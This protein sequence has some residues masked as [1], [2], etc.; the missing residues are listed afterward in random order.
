[1]A[2]EEQQPFAVLAAAS[3]EL[4]RLDLLL[5]DAAVEGAALRKELAVSVEAAVAAVSLEH[6]ASFTEPFRRAGP[7]LAGAAATRR[8]P[9]LFVEDEPEQLH[10]TGRLGDSWLRH[11]AG[12]EGTESE[13]ASVIKSLR[14]RLEQLEAG[15]YAKRD[16]LLPL[17][18][19]LLP[20]PE[21]WR[22]CV[23][24]R[25]S[26]PGVLQLPAAA[27]PSAVVA[28]FAGYADG[29]LEALQ[30]DLGLLRSFAANPAQSA[31]AHPEEGRQVGALGLSGTQLADELVGTAVV[32]SFGVALGALRTAAAAAKMQANFE[33]VA[34]ALEAA[35][36]CY[37]AFFDAASRGG[38][39]LRAAS[40]AP[41]D[42]DSSQE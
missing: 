28:A 6:G 34:E 14:Q 19:P 31:A 24:W 12:G 25:A 23:M 4:A 2:M 37:A 33:G 41:A 17:L 22:I 30:Q 7:L 21:L 1:M 16:A 32:E 38:T 10:G 29:V 36:G 39:I 35:V 27:A 3:D 40:L 18:A 26:A 5:A 9:E 13:R 15:A 42:A 11:Q 8:V 20:L